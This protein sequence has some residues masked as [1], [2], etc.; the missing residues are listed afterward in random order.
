[1][2]TYTVGLVVHM[3]GMAVLEDSRTV[4]SGLPLLQCSR[5]LQVLLSSSKK[6]VRMDSMMMDMDTEEDI[7]DITMAGEDAPA[8]RGTH[9]S[10]RSLGSAEVK[11]G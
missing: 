6:V 7:I 8:C 10:G 5:K 11:L 2:V 9:T 3:V 1:M 4:V